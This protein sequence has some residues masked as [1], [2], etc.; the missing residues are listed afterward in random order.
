MSRP[1]DLGFMQHAM[2]L[3][4]RGW[5]TTAPN[6]LVGAVI[7]ER[8]KVVAEGWHER[9]GEAHAE[10]VALGNLGKKTARSATLY[11][12]LEP[13]STPGRTGACCEAITAAKIKRVVIG[14]MDPNPA[15]AGRAVELLQSA[16]VEV[17]SGVAA[18][19][20]EDLNLIFNHWIT[21]GVPLIAAKMANTL[22]GNI[23]TRNGDSKWITNEA[24]RADV[25]RWRRLF[26]AIAVGAM[27]VLEDNP[28]LTARWPEG[29]EWSP[30]RFV[31][32]GLLRTVVDRN[33]PKLYGDEFRSNTIVVTTPHGGLGYVRKLE[34]AGIQVWVIPSDSQQVP[35][36]AFKQRCADAGISGVYAE[37][38]ANLIG[39]LLRERELDYLFNY[40]APVLFADQ[41]ARSGFTG[42]RTERLRDA[43]RLAKVRHANFGDDQLLRGH[44]VYP[45]KVQVDEG[46]VRR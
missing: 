13:C 39:N 9:D 23:A 27:T 40:R 1:E 12:T 38:G 29:E 5:G 32:D 34:A 41:K 22:D 46:S 14:A 2:S 30:T 4:R 42:L 44:V 18:D 43:V 21:R 3:A 28:K 11:V 7:V 8:G 36:A 37:G 25:H 16:G 31:F 24:S 35:F 19:E 20:C 17:T 45:E 6:P 10:R 26:P 15:H 33:M